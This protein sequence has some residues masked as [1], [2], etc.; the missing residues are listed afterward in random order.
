MHVTQHDSTREKTIVAL[1]LRQH[2]AQR[3]YELTHFNIAIILYS[4]LS[5]RPK[6]VSQNTIQLEQSIA[7]VRW[8][9]ILYH[10]QFY[11]LNFRHKDD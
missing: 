4:G 3:N 2:S 10:V 8:L 7:W 5:L 9:E 1:I 11:A 6:G